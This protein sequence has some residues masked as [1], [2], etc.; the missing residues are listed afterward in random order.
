MGELYR[1]PARNADVKKLSDRDS[2]FVG[3]AAPEAQPGKFVGIIDNLT[4]VWGGGASLGYRG[5]KSKNRTKRRH[6]LRRDPAQTELP[7]SDGALVDLE[8]IRKFSLR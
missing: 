5:P 4:W 6:V 1:F 2:T 3:Q 7:L 8:D